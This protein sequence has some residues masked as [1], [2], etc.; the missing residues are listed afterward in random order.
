M[1]NRCLL[2]LHSDLVRA[3]ILHE[4]AHIRRNDYLA[5]LVQ[6]VIDSTLFYSFGPWDSAESVQAMRI[7]PQAQA[8]MARVRELCTEAAPGSYRVAATS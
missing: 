8:G 1:L 3:V 5:N 7:D 2:F 6:S 4:L